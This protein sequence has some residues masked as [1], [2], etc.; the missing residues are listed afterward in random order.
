MSKQKR[1]LKETVNNNEDSKFSADS[2]QNYNSDMSPENI[3]RSIYSEIGK[4]TTYLR[5]K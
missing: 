2:R 5:H 3:S 4:K 1:T